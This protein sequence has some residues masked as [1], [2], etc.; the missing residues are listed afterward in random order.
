[1]RPA[2]C[3][4]TGATGYLGRALVA[5]LA[6]RGHRVRALVRPQSAGR[7]PRG[8]EAIEGDALDAASIAAALRPGD[9]LVQLVGTPH[10]GP[11]KGTQFRAVD[12]VSGHAAV[13]AAVRAGA[14]HFVYLSVAQ[15]APVMQAYIDVRAGVESAIRAS[16]LTAT[17]LRPWYVLGPG[18]WWPLALQP[19]YALAG[20]LPWTRPLSERLGLVT[21]AQMVDALVR[22]IEQPPAA[23]EVRLVDVP[24]IRSAGGDRAGSQ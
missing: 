13:A 10:P 11:H 16:G 14:S 6:P 21:L 1:M 15:P 22:A 20:A 23:R 7:L 2:D 5:A 24:G 18:H 19:F 4:V 8:V 12:A 17:V 3:L 9:T